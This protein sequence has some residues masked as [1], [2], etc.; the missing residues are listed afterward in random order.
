MKLLSLALFLQQLITVEGFTNSVR[1]VPSTTTGSLS[2]S[3]IQLKH[4]LG[5]G[6]EHDDT[7]AQFEQQQQQDNNNVPSW[8]NMAM[9]F[10]AGLAFASTMSLGVAPAF[11]ADT[12]IDT[13]SV[14]FL[15]STTTVVLSAAEVKDADI[16]DFSMPSYQDASRAAVNSNLKG[17]NYLLGEASK[18][19]QS[20]SSPTTAAV[21]TKTESADDVKARKAAAKAAMQAARAQQQAEAEIAVKAAAAAKE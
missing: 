5:G 2:L 20:S 15:T 1:V 8:N 7:T 4:H 19:Y 9:K 10:V 12:T 17:D 21:E 18:N 14:S 3:S 11:A 6:I 13:S 16:A